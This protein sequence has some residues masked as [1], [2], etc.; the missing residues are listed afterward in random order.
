MPMPPPVVETHDETQTHDESAL[1][2]DPE[3][4][5]QNIDVS[6][7]HAAVG[8]L[9]EDIPRILA[10]GA[11]PNNKVVENCT[12]VIHGVIMDYPKVIK[13]LIDYEA[14]FVDLNTVD[15]SG[16]TPLHKC[17]EHGHVACAKVLLNAACITT[18]AKSWM[19]VFQPD[20]V[21]FGEMDILK[22]IALFA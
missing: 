13:A 8:G 9:H 12:P 10:K 2:I 19:V 22:L 5:Q 1:N 6:L 17:V 18:R 21:L 15:Q 16:N 7:C 14:V 3:M 4:D 11:N 20:H